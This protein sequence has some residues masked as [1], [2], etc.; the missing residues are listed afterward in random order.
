MAYA[1]VWLMLMYGLCLCMA[2]A[3]VW[4]ML[5]YNRYENL[6]LTINNYNIVLDNFKFIFSH[7]F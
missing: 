6:F 3:Y 2:Y 4:L 7:F 5:M 1:Y